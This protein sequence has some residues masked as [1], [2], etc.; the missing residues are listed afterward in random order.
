MKSDFCPGVA[1]AAS[2][3]SIGNPWLVDGWR[4]G[5]R[6]ALPASRQ[7]ADAGADCDEHSHDE[8]RERVAEAA[9]RLTVELARAD[10]LAQEVRRAL[11]SHRGGSSRPGPA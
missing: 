9:D 6:V 8:T 7:H 5:T 4:G 11:A 1:T 3:T 10:R 2:P